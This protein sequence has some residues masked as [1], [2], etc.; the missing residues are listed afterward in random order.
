MTVWITLLPIAILGLLT[1]I[2]LKAYE[3]NEESDE[4]YAMQ[5]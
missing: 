5:D 4:E 2:G 1:C 3:L